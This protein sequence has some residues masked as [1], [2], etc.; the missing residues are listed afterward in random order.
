MIQISS[1]QFWEAPFRYIVLC[2]PFGL[3]WCFLLRMEFWWEMT[4]EMK[5]PCHDVLSGGE[6]CHHATW[7]AN[8]GR[9][10]SLNC[11]YCLFFF[12]CPSN[13]NTKSSAH[14][15]GFVEKCFFYLFL[16]LFSFLFTLVWIC[17]YLYYTILFSHCLN[18]HDWEYLDV[19]HCEFCLIGCCTVLHSCKSSWVLLWKAVCSLQGLLSCGVMLLWLR[20]S[21]PSW[22]STS[23]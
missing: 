5:L 21:W 23:L 20:P 17:V 15:R 22:P 2:P 14:A 19:K 10:R 7:D 13:A 8:L 12:L 6:G 9:R 4:T 1:W 11:V 18:F 3:L 16:F